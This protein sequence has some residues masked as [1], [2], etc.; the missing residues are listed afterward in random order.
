MPDVGAES[1]N[2][3]SFSTRANRNFTIEDR[4]FPIKDAFLLTTALSV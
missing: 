2:M 4:N 1:H 3:N